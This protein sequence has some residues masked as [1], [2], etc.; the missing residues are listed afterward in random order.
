MAKFKDI[1]FAREDKDPTGT[2]QKIP[3]DQIQP[4]RYQ[5]R[6]QFDAQAM[7]ELE[8]SILANGLITPLTVRVVDDHY[9]IIAGERRYRACRELGME[10]VPCYVLSPDENQAAQMALVENIQRADLTAIEEAKAYVQIMRQGHL[11][12]EEVAHRV[13]R[14]QSSVANKIRLLNLPQEIQDGVRDQTITERH[15][16]ALLSVPPQKQIKVY[17]MIV[18]KDWT[19]RAT[20]EYIEKMDSAPRHRQKT[21]G[22]ARGFRIGLNSVEQC[23]RM[24]QKMGVEVTMETQEKEEAVQVVL[25]FPKKAKE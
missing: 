9:E 22:Y 12:Q 23:V 15:A 18:E 24:L 11:T 16:R 14:S 4:S 19:V 6:L 20:E 21:K 1:L 5:P 25:R 7:A 10:T 8:A 2:V 17:R 3:L 13:G